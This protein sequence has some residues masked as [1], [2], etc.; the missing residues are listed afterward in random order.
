M[1]DT[2]SMKREMWGVPYFYALEQNPCRDGFHIHALWCDCK[3]KSRREIWRIW[4]ERCGRNRIEPL[5]SRD[6]MADYCAKYVT[7]E[8][9]WCDIKLLRHRHP[10]DLTNY[11]LSAEN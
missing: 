10:Q 3:N 4:F 9:S 7:K 5:N 1:G 2:C 11:A 8:G 6:N